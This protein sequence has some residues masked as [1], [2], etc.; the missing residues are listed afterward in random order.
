MEICALASLPLPAAMTGSPRASTRAWLL[1]VVPRNLQTRPHAAAI[2]RSSRHPT[3]RCCR[4]ASPCGPDAMGSISAAPPLTLQARTTRR[5]PTCVRSAAAPAPGALPATRTT[6]GSASS[7]AAGRPPWRKRRKRP[8][9]RYTKKGTHSLA[10]DVA[11]FG[12]S[13][14]HSSI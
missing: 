2:V 6:S 8:V 3:R 1:Q 9:C 11:I 5:R 4:L 14:H 13:S 10:I 12:S 7:A